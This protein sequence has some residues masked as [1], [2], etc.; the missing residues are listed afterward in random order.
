M[1]MKPINAVLAAAICTIGFSAHAAI[2]KAEHK[3]AVKDR[4]SVV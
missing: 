3:V 1:N 4:K 2:S